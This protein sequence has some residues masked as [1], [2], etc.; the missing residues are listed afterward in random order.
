MAEDEG[1]VTPVSE[2]DM[3][4]EAEDV[5]AATTMDGAKDRRSGGEGDAKEEGR[6][7]VNEVGSNALDAPRVP[8]CL[9]PKRGTCEK[10]S[11]EQQRKWQDRTQ[12][13][14][15]VNNSV[16]P[17]RFSPTRGC[18]TMGSLIDLVSGEES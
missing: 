15:G 4:D 11:E 14:F 18:G 17:L 13:L 16:P 1:I 7:A 8:T 6:D 2:A 5:G 12:T 3:E 9:F 10:G